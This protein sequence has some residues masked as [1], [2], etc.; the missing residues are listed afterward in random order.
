MAKQPKP[1]THIFK[2]I[3]KGKY[4]TVKRFEL[5]EVKNG[6]PLLEPIVQLANNRA[7]AKSKPLY[8]F[9]HKKNNKW[10]TP[11]L[12]GL[13]STEVNNLYKGDIDNK[14]NLL[15]FIIDEVNDTLIV[16]YYRSYFTYDLLTILN[17][18]RQ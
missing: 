3:N 8:W 12:T 4:A 15:L 13:F 9:M 16:H 11:R 10:V 1:V 5:V 7:F 14:T 18:F 6:E 17:S 2:E